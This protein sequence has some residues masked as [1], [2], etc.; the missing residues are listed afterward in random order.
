MATGLDLSNTQA[1]WKSRQKADIGEWLRIGSEMNQW[2][3]QLAGRDDLVVVVEPGSGRGAPAVYLPEEGSVEIDP[4]VCAAGTDPADIRMGDEAGRLAH[5]AFAGAGGHE[6]GHGR[7]SR[8]PIDQD[9]RKR[10]AVQAA[11]MLEE[12]AMEGDLI[13]DHPGTRTLLRA[14]FDKIVNTGGEPATTIAGAAHMACLCHGR[15]DAGVLDP[16]EAA[17][18]ID[19]CRTIIGDRYDALRRVWLDVQAIGV[20]DDAAVMEAHGQAWLDILGPDAAT[21]GDAGALIFVCGNPPAGDADSTLAG[22]AGAVSAAATAEAAAQAAA[23]RAHDDAARRDKGDAERRK[24]AAA[25][26]DVFKGIEFVGH[27]HGHGHGAEGLQGERPPTAA[28]TGRASALASELARA[29]H[30]ERARTTRPSPVPPGR[31][32]TAAAVRRSAERSQGMMSTT[33]PWQRTMRRRTDQP[34]ITVAIGCDISGS[35]REVTAAVASAAWVIARAVHLGDGD[36]ATVAYGNQVHAVVRPGEAPAMVR[37]FNANGGME[38][39][40]GAMRALNGALDLERARGA[41]LAVFISDGQYTH[42]Q[43]A[44]GDA[45]A[46]QLMASGV[47]I[48]WLGFNGTPR[49][50]IVPGA[51]YVR[52][53]DPGRIGRIIGEAM[54]ELLEQT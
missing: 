17:P 14:A 26:E 30:R 13:R 4:D 19:G 52:I 20:R 32:R 9:P 39:W 2:V 16:A 11:L 25:A 27:G 15:V 5:P 41:R 45:M 6:G 3:N 21:A 33:M 31:L 51:K 38:N 7:Y 1:W 50:T 24:D 35:M 23:A 42:R 44:E 54:I 34:P 37:E 48:L 22:V 40:T 12:P 28:E 8:W 10:A 29:R 43:R 53:N 18:I 47:K 46:K 36:T 49:D